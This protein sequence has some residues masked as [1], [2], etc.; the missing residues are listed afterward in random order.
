M[1][2]PAEKKTSWKFL[3]NSSWPAMNLKVQTPYQHKIPRNEVGSKFSENEEKIQ[4]SI[5]LTF[6]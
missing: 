5:Y 1:Q 4:I 6:Y 3:L 2:N